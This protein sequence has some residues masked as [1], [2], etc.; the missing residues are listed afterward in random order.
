MHSRIFTANFKEAQLAYRQVEFCS[1]GGIGH[2][3]AVCFHE[4]G[5]RVFATARDRAVLSSLESKGIETLSLVVD[6]ENSVQECHQQI[7]HLTAGAGLDYLVNNAGR[8]YTVPCLDVK[9]DEVRS[10]FETN[11]FAVMRLVQIF[12]DDLIKARGTIVMIGSVAG[13]VPYV[14]G[15]AYNASKAALHAYSNTLRVEM[16]PLGVNVITIVTGGVK[17]NI[18]RTKRTL[19]EKSLYSDLDEQYQIRQ[20]H[21]QTVGM[22]NEQYAKSVVNQVLPGAGPWP[23]RWLLHDARK[24]WIWEGSRSWLVWYLCGGWTW[25]GLPDRVLSRMFGLQRVKRPA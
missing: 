4:A 13:V 1:P 12:A 21:S 3:L 2:S 10:V 20:K 17:S 18:A 22:S 7:Q 16:E 25:Y 24:R 15:G 19:P 23:W 8:N 5:L 14:F 9:M 6:D 11:L